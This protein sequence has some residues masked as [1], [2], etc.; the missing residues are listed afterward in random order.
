PLPKSARLSA[1]AGAKRSVAMA[2]QAAVRS[3]VTSSAGR[4]ALASPVVASSKVNSPITPGMPSA[5]LPSTRVSILKTAKL[6]AAD[7]AGIASM[8]KSPPPICQ[9][10][11]SGTSTSP[12]ASAR[13]AS[14][15]AGRIAARPIC[16]AMSRPLISRM[17]PGPLPTGGNAVLAVVGGAAIGAIDRL[18][19][20][21][22]AVRL[23]L[24]RIGREQQCLIAAHGAT[25]G[26]HHLVSHGL[27]LLTDEF[28]G[29]GFQP[30]R[31]GHLVVVKA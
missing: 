12:S 13:K 28:I 29:F 18:L 21:H 25:I 27:K 1:S 23:G 2:L 11:R 19:R 15:I 8:P 31:V 9:P 30:H 26:R 14:R 22:A 5:R 10:A 16:A 7:R 20:V 4:R 24:F 6:S 17:L 3:K